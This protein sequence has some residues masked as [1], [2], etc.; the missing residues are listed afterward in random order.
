MAGMEVES[1]IYITAPNMPLLSI[2]D[3]RL[4]LHRCQPLAQT[5]IDLCGESSGNRHQID[6]FYASS[7]LLCAQFLHTKSLPK[8]LIAAF[9]EQKPFLVSNADACDGVLTRRQPDVVLEHGVGQGAPHL[10]V[11]G[12]VRL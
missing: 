4:S 3:C 7:M 11:R 8:T 10:R 6:D 1:V 2:C 12:V 9:G 5:K